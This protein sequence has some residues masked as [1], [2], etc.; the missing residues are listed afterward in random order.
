MKSWIEIIIAPI[1]TMF[2][3]QAIKLATDGVKGNFNIKNFLTTYG[4]MPSGH[5]AYVTAVSAAVALTQGVENPLFAV[6]VIFSLLVITDA[7][8][9]RRRIDI[10][11][12]VANQ[13]ISQLPQSEQNGFT[14]IKAK[15]EH[16]F[17]QVL[18]GVGSGIIIASL[19][20]IIVS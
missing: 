3:V 1:V 14:T 10:V 6:A 7:M 18:V 17:P 16:T 12:R 15:I 20:H 11:A 19:I 13:L 9:L 5:A 4:G 8:F 2:I